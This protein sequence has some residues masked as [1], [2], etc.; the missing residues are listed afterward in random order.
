MANIN[1]LLKMSIPLGRYGK[2]HFLVKRTRER[3]EFHYGVGNRT[4]DGMYCVFLDYDDTPYEWIRE[5]IRLLQERM[6]CGHAHVFK[7]NKGFHVIF[8]EKYPLDELLHILGMTSVDKSYI[9]VP[10]KYANK[11]WVLRQTHKRDM[12]ITYV[13]TIKNTF[14][15]FRE[16]STA[17][18]EYL[19]RYC[20]LDEESFE[21]HKWDGQQEL[22]L[23]YYYAP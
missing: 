21:K 6:G 11:V 5:E 20:Y 23:G 22:V 2:L 12:P 10:L 17:H 8:L 16:K 9:H 3:K 7:T 13:E 4:K 19:I 1:E 14:S 18:K 15:T